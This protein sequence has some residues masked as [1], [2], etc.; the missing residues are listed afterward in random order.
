MRENYSAIVF[1]EHGQVHFHHLFMYYFKP[2][3]SGPTISLVDYT[4]KSPFQELLGN[5]IKWNLFQ[6]QQENPK[7]YI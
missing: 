2:A 1:N 6:V 3:C 7:P 5:L 4:D